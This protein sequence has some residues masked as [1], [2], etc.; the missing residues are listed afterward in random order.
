MDEN[1]NMRRDGVT[2]AALVVAWFVAFA[3]AVVIAVIALIL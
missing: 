1:E 3:L 2:V